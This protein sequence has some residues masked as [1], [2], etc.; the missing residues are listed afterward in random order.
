MTYKQRTQK[1][2]YTPGPFSFCRGKDGCDEIIYIVDTVHEK[3]LASIYLCWDLTPEKLAEAT[4]NAVLFA[5]A[6][7][8][9]E[10]LEM[11]LKVAPHRGPAWCEAAVRQ[12]RALLAYVTDANVSQPEAV[13]KGVNGKLQAKE[14]DAMSAGKEDSHE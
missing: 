11:L 7:E 9:V 3:E 5:A 12:A 14:S 1:K 8:L 10:A 2:M 13:G 4:A 6:P